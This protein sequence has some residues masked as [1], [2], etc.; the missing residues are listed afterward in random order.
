LKTIA[1]DEHLIARAIA[2]YNNNTLHEL[3]NELMANKK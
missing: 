1:N 3:L 2:S